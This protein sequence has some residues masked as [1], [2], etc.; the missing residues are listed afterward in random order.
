MALHIAN[1][2]V[3]ND[4]EALSAICGINKTEAVGQAVRKALREK[5]QMSLDEAHIRF[6]ELVAELQKIPTD[7]SKPDPLEWDE[8]GLPI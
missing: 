7:Y 2:E 3:I 6:Q 4:V 5:Q 1:Q 8:N